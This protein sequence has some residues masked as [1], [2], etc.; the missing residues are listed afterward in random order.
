MIVGPMSTDIG[1][2]AGG[3]NVFAG[4]AGV[5]GVAALAPAAVAPLANRLPAA[6]TAARA[7]R[8]DSM[9]GALS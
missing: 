4:V 2:T 6:T 1:P 3:T 7:L 8:G 5:T 9:V